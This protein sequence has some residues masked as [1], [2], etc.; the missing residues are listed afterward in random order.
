MSNP[1]AVALLGECLVGRGHVILDERQ[2][3]VG[4]SPDLIAV[5]AHARRWGS[6]A[7]IS[8]IQSCIN[9]ASRQ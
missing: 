5:Q 6:V 4:G 7:T 1:P 8:Q 9:Y 2:A 3:R